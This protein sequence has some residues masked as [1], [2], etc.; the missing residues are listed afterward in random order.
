MFL[1]VCSAVAALAC[2]DLDRSVGPRAPKPIAEQE[3]P[4]VLLSLTC[5]LN[6]SESTVSC[7]PV[8]P[9]AAPGVNASVIYGA[10]ARYAIFFPYNLVKDT[11]A[12]TWQ[13][14]A[15]LQNLLK[16]SIGSLN[17]TT[18]TGVKV[19]VTDVHAT[20]GTGA[21]SVANADGTG[22]F[23][24]PNQPYFNYNQII[25]PSGYSG[26]KLWKF[27][28]RNSVTAV[29][30]SILIS[31][32]FP[33]QQNVTLQPPADLP[34]WVFKD[35]SWTKTASGVPFFLKRTMS[36]LFRVGT[37]LADRQLAIAYIGGTVVGG[38]RLQSGDGF[39][40]VTVPDD[41]TGTQL[42]AAVT[43]IKTL[44]Q[45]EA[46]AVQHRVQPAYLRPNDGTGWNKWSLNP[47]SVSAGKTWALEAIDAPFASGCT[48]G[49]ANVKIGVIDEGFEITEVS[50]NV[51]LVD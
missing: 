28:V 22:T 6:G 26:N 35:S 45:V 20:T 8:L 21:V 36:V 47:G 18:T 31:T 30:V 40:Y 25:A 38:V 29:S 5:D 51:V 48:T 34:A 16:Q 19:F 37:T 10:T 44:P 4:A 3:G 13:F 39:Y 50:D 43:R 49:D 17:G 27:N 46:A 33:A 23:T 1:V 7:T 2:N 32:E 12:H 41:G 42:N 15:H 11:L 14:T 24:A 9:A